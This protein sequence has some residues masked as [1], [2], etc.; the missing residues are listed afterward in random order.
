M[1]LLFATNNK[2]KIKEVRQILEP[3]IKIRSL[4]EVNFSEDLP[5]TQ[6]TLEGN[7]SQK[8]WYVFNNFLK[9]SR[10]FHEIDG[11]FADD[12]GLEI[13]ALNGRPGVFSA[14]YAGPD[15]N[16]E[17][18]IRKVLAEMPEKESRK[19]VFRCVISLIIEGKELLFEGKMEGEILRE[20]RGIE[21]FGYDPIFAPATKGGPH[22]LKS[23]AEMTLSE[24]N[25]ISHRAAAVRK[26]EN[27]LGMR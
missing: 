27:Y 19:A 1:T 14:R 9:S 20:K 21:G 10:S 24:K 25:R 4:A 12:T 26:M 5:E 13:E 2:N 6:D 3:A 22:T 11:C 23:F 8:A 15:C 18:N 7:A 17:D 16:P